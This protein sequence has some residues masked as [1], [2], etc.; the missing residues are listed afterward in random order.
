MLESGSELVLLATEVQVDI[1][2]LLMARILAF[3]AADLL[4]DKR[5]LSVCF[6]QIVSI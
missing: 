5:K 4:W 6:L 1:R 2:K 3:L